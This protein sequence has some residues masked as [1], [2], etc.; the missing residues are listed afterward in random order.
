MATCMEAGVVPE[1]VEVSQVESLLTVKAKPELVEE[2]VSACAA[3][4]TPEV[5]LNESE[6]GATLN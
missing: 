2:S 3:D 5:T 1:V 6:A 4:A